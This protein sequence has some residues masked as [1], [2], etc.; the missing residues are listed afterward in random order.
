MF[1]IEANWV[2]E[3]ESVSK[4]CCLNKTESITLGDLVHGTARTAH[5]SSGI[6]TLSNWQID[7]RLGRSGIFIVH[8]RLSIVA[9][10]ATLP[11]ALDVAY[12]RLASS[13]CLSVWQSVCSPVQCAIIRID[14]NS[15]YEDDTHTHTHTHT[16]TRTHTQS[17]WWPSFVEAYNKILLTLNPFKPSGAKWLHYKVF[18][19]ILV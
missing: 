9:G 12:R 19:A 4:L 5:L 2:H 18:K 1:S 15:K 14:E 8:A 11:E 6:A 10:S 13:V 16:N 3:R 17:L 7:P